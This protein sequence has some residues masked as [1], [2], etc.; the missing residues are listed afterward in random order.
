[1]VASLTT[2][3]AQDTVTWNRTTWEGAMIKF[4]IL[5]RIEQVGKGGKRKYINLAP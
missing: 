2:L 3:Q 4:Q 5:T 1:L